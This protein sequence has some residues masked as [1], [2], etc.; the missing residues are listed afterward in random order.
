MMF[1]QLLLLQTVVSMGVFIYFCKR[2]KK[3]PV[4]VDSGAEP[5]AYFELFNRQIA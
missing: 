1:L 4:M 5:D 3:A 2:S